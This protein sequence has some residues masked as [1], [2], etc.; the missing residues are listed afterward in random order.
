MELSDYSKVHQLYHREVHRMKGHRVVIQEKIDGSQL[1][2]GRKEGQLFVRSKNRMINIE[3]PDGM[4]A[5]AVEVLKD[6]PLPDNYVF[7]GEYLKVPKHNVLDYD[8]IPDGHIIIYDIE[9]HDGSNHYL[10]TMCVKEM[11]DA[12]EFEVVPTF[13]EFIFEEVTAGTI[14]D[15]MKTKSILG[16][17]LIEGLVFKCYDVFDSRDKTLMCKFVRPEV[18]E[19]ITGKRGKNRRD[20]IEEIGDRL[21]TPA[22]FEKAVQ[23]LRDSN[24]L[25]DE[26]KDIGVLMQELNRDFEEHVDEIKNLL[27]ENF[28]KD[29]LRAANRGFATWYKDLLLKYSI[30]T[31]QKMQEKEDELRAEM[32]DE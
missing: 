24:M 30:P 19:M 3:N 18:R 21:S 11:A 15:L 20:I 1:S 10:D 28:R 25:V 17:Q 23:H 4:F 6:R 14:E 27:Y 22:R 32:T 5:L 31:F 2:F 8:R 7:R 29:I 13:G 9:F 12:Y 16:G 26:P